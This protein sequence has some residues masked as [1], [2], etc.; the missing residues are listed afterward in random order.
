[1]SGVI[2]RELT[3]TERPQLSIPSPQAFILD[4]GAEPSLGGGEEGDLHSIA[5]L[6]LLGLTPVVGTL[7]PSWA[8]MIFSAG[9]AIAYV[10]FFFQTLVSLQGVHSLNAFVQ[11]LVETIWFYL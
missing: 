5:D 7:P 9:D 10:G 4:S 6:A 3:V 8:E 11:Q 1:M 2:P